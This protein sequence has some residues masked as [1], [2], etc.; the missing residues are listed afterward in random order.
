MFTDKRIKTFLINSALPIQVNRFKNEIGDI[1]FDIIID[2]GSHFAVD[3]L[4]TLQNLYPLVK[5][6]GYYIIEDITVGSTLQT[7][8]QLI[9][10]RCNNDPFVFV[11]LKNNICAIYKNSI[12]LNKTRV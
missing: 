5:D 4:N 11:G 3:Q 10:N 12:K 9:V 6:G 7:Q 2:D 8:P 1:K